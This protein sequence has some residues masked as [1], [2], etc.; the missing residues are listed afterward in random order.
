MKV[1]LKKQGGLAGGIRW[2]IKVVEST[3]LIQPVADELAKLVSAAKATAK[4]A[5]KPSRARDSMT[6]TITIEGESGESTV[7]QQSDTTMSPSFA[8]L[9]EWLE[10]LP[11]TK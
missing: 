4:V 1:T 10:R 3:S 2:P 8:A 9:L 5:E 6:F 7:I 11:E